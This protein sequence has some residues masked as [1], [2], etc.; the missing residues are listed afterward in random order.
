MNYNFNNT[1]EGIIGDKD[2][3]KHLVKLDRVK[4]NETLTF[5][6]VHDKNKGTFTCKITG[7]KQVVVATGKKAGEAVNDAI[8][9]ALQFMRNEKQTTISKKQHARCKARKVAGESSVEE[10]NSL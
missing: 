2:V 4:S 9:K 3:Q 6:I 1:V 7:L 10:S 8:K 5:E